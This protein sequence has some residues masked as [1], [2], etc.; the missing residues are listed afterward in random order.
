MKGS[1]D[2]KFIKIKVW[3]LIIKQN[4]TSTEQVL[5][6]NIYFFSIK[7]NKKTMLLH[8]SVKISRQEE[9][10]NS[11]EQL[12]NLCN[13]MSLSKK[14]VPVCPFLSLSLYLCLTI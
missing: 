2:S 9:N 14:T 3:V 6:V 7:T 11:I 13:I 5:V 8:F 10:S 12:M 1:I 4:M